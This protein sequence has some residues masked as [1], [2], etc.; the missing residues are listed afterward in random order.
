[1]RTTRHWPSGWWMPSRSVRSKA[2]DAG[3]VGAQ[4]KSPRCRKATGAFSCLEQSDLDLGPQLDHPV[5]RQLEEAQVTVGIL[6][7]EGEQ[8]L[9]P[10]RHPDDLRSDHRLTD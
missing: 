4:T 9:P 8:A 10:A 7:H 6:Q 2:N 1:M 3:P 5:H